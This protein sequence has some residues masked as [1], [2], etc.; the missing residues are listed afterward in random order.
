MSSPLATEM[1]PIVN[2][3]LS[4]VGAVASYDRMIG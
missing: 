2:S 3:Q 1:K 4:S